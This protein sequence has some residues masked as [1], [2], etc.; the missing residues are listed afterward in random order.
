MAKKV[1]S[2]PIQRQVDSVDCIQHSQ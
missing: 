1:S 2:E